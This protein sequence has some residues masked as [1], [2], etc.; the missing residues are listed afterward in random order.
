M[1]QILKKIINK[2]IN[3]IKN[4]NKKLKIYNKKF[5][6]IWIIL[7]KNKICNNIKNKKH[8][9]NLK[10]LIITMK[11]LKNYKNNIMWFCL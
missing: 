6:M 1:S 3:N 5:H 9:N 10:N 7:I 11:F 8:A 4:I 2:S